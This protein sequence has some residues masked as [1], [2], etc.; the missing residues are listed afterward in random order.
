MV[1]LSIVIPAYNEAERLPPTL[2]AIAAYLGSTGL[3]AEVIVVDDGS[4][5]GTAEAARNA[6]GV[7]MPPQVLRHEQ[8]R[9]KGAAVREG[10]L[11]AEGEYIL[12]M[13]ADS[14]LPIEEVA[15]LLPVAEA[16][17]PVVIGSRYVDP[18]S[19]HEAQRW[20]RAAISR[21]GNYLVQRLLLPGISDT[22]CGFKLLRRE[23]GRQL[24]SLLTVDRFS[25]DMELLVDAK[26]LGLEVRE[27]P[28]NCYYSHGTRLRPVWSSLQ[29][30]RDL[31]RIRSKLRRGAVGGAAVGVGALSR[32][33]APAGPA[34]TMLWCSRFTAATAP[35]PLTRWSRRST[36][37]AP[38]GTRSSSARCT[39]R[40]SSW[41]RA[42]PARPAWPSCWRAP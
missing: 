8:N 21:F 14:S 13:D 19:I 11:A 25:F 42:A 7:A 6:T 9:G 31:L 26:Q 40:I 34:A 38:C 39:T 16:G 32:S 4:S 10:I 20:Y 18:D 3:D 41:D 24:A 1:T 5:D 22:Q 23:E 27:V 29:T 35:E 12:F 17:T 33:P 36:S 2:T 15:K 30:F 37:C 28:V